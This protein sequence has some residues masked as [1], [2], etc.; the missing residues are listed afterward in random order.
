M[1]AQQGEVDMDIE[2]EANEM[3]LKANED[4]YSDAILE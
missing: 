2:L 4:E 3:D 1:E